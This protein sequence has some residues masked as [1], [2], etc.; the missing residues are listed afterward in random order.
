MNSLPLSKV[1]IEDRE[2]QN[3]CDLLERGEHPCRAWFGTDRFSAGPVA[4]SVTVTV[5]V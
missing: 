5:R 4:M 3:R 2:V 1:N